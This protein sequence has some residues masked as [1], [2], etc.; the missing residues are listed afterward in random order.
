MNSLK[1]PVIIFDFGGVLVDWSPYY[2]YRQVMDNDEEIKAFLDEI[3]FVYWNTQFDKGYPFS[4]GIEEKCARFPHREELIRLF[5]SRWLDA[6]GEVMTAT[7]DVVRGL[8][9]A[10][11][12]LYG[13]S[14]WSFEKFNLVKD[15]CEFLD[16]LDD[17]LLSGQVKLIKPESEIFHLLLNKIGQPAANCLFVDDNLEN[18]KAA[19]SLGF[20]TI[21][22]QS[23]GQLVQDLKSAGIRF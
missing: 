19:Q 2:L 8:K 20:Q 5:N 23:A 3:D 4:K 15:R 11:Y 10:G 9:Q 12:S 22:F 14:N 18:I 16:Y 1:S 6:M 17:Y 21:R 13:L 7:V